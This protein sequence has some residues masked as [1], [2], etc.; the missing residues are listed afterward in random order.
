MVSFGAVLSV[1]LIGVWI[2]A[3]FD[4]LTS[5]AAK[6]RSLQKPMWVLIV[7]LFFPLLPIGAFAWFVW[8]RPRVGGGETGGGSGG[9]FGGFGGGGGGGSWGT[10]GPTDRGPRGG[11]GA[12]RPRRQPIAPD[13]DPD[14]LKTL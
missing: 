7:L 5:N 14:F 8:G 2:F 3:L 10:R 4:A 1:V 9:G 12:A 13:D 6:I 11:S